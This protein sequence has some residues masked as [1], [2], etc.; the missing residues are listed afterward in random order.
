MKYP[1][2]DEQAFINLVGKAHEKYGPYLPANVRG[3]LELV[4]G[5]YGIGYDEKGRDDEYTEKFSEDMS[6]ALSDEEIGNLLASE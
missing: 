2:N 3:Q 1:M 4:A 6:D 5:S